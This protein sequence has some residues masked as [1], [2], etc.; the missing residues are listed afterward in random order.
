MPAYRY[1]DLAHIPREVFICWPTTDPDPLP[2]GLDGRSRVMLAAMAAPELL[3]DD[4]AEPVDMA[5]RRQ[6]DHGDA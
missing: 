5:M 4:R 1:A 6:L 3:D 2:D